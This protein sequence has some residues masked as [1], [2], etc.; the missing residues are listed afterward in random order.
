MKTGKTHIILFARYPVAGQAK[1]RLVPELGP[2]QAARLH[3]RMTE[4]AACVVRA[5]CR[6][7]GAEATVFFTGGRGREFRAWLGGGLGYEEQTSG[8]LGGRLR[9]AFDA[10]FR[11]GAGKALA[12]GSDVPGISPGVLL[13][14]AGR[15]G[16]RE[17]VIGPAADGGYYLIGMTRPLPRLFESIEWGTERVFGQTM[18]AV[19]S[20]GIK[21]AVLP[22]VGDVDRPE[23][24]PIVR[25]H[26]AF[27]WFFAGKPMISVIIPALNE[28]GTIGKTIERARRAE[29]VEV[30]VSDGGSID[31]TCEAAS[32]AGAAV[33]AG[34]PGRAAQ[35][36]AGAALARGQILL[37]LHADTLLP[38]GYDALV[39]DSLED[40]SVVAGAFAFRT[41]GRGPAM[42]LVEKAANL[43]STF[44]GLPYGD[45]GLFME[46]RVFDGAGGFAPLPFMED[47]ELVRRLRARGRVITL[48][49]HV[50]TSCRRW[51]RMGV[52]R[53]ALLN[54]FVIAA[55]LAGV[56][57]RRL[58]RLYR[59]G[60]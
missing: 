31:S 18:E 1:T 58:G 53:A 2:E 40:P 29:A 11:R 51:R 15:L 9:Q 50:V 20:Y 44:L 60:G 23:D 56:G 30:I 55:Y 45:Q 47:F 6:D 33:V 22:E 41:D 14:A 52:I 37:F 38:P 36:N 19:R 57:P 4:H 43:R 49:E 35:M 13:E 28:A 54:Q 42:R 3:R 48:K 25:E 46:R 8:D 21:A 59:G 34:G 5:A 7:W 16:E 24:L 17:V 32:G 27:K 26:P 39:R 10:A 12:I